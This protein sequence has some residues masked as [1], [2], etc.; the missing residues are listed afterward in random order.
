MAAKVWLMQSTKGCKDKFWQVEVCTA[1]E[2]GSK[3]EEFFLHAGAEGFYELLYQDGVTNNLNNDET[4]LYFFFA[5]EF[6]VR[7]F[8]P[9]ALNVL[10]FQNVDYKICSVAF[11]DYIEMFRNTFS[12]FPL[13]EKTWLVP[14]WDQEN[15]AI[16]PEAAHLPL[17]PGLAFGTGKHASTQLMIEFLEKNLQKGQSVFDLGCGSGILSIGALLFGARLAMGVDVEQISVDSA[18][19]NAK[20]L[21][22]EIN[23]NA[24]IKFLRGDFKFYKEKQFV[25]TDIFLANILPQVFMKNKD[26][27]FYYLQN[28]PRW[29]LSGIS[30]TQADMFAEFL[31]QGNFSFSTKEKDGWL[32][33]FN[34]EG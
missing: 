21:P 32:I 27:L 4:V 13:T 12:A 25:Q 19:E 26:D 14:P 22:L 7:A 18:I 9:M 2:Y 16:P 5:A 3:I 10:G 30:E 34:G 8:V 15:P 28:T 24:E 1:K 31:S 11:E 29:A 33:L 17:S 23:K 20:L 6:P